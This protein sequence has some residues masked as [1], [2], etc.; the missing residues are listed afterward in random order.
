M[1]V[2]DYDSLD[3]AELSNDLGEK[4]GTIVG[5]F[6]DDSSSTPTWVA[7]RSGLFGHHHSLV[8]LAQSRWEQGRLLVPY[9]RD[10][11]AAAP[12]GDPDVALDATQEKELFEHYNVGYSDGDRPG[13]HT[14]VE[15]DDTGLLGTADTGSHPVEFGSS[16]IEAAQVAGVPGLPTG[17]GPEKSAR[18]RR[19]VRGPAS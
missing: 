9:T 8:P 2:P 10:D 4:L 14:G 12:H 1:Q 19:Y 18:L 6:I 17:P 16:E 13:P 5:L 15:A 3:G 11:L 7:V